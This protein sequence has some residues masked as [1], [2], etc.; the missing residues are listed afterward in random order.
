[1]DKLK[2]IELFL[3]KDGYFHFFSYFCKLNRNVFVKP[4]A[5]RYENPEKTIGDDGTG[6]TACHDECPR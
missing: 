2:G 5:K 4:N 3:Q 6:G 1:M